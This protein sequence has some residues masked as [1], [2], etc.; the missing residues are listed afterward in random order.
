MK[1]LREKIEQEQ[2]RLR[3]VLGE[4]PWSTGAY[5]H[6][7]GEMDG[8]KKTLKWLDEEEQS[9]E[10]KANGM[11]DEASGNEDQKHPDYTTKYFESPWKPISDKQNNKPMG[12]PTGYTP[13]QLCPKCEAKKKRMSKEDFFDMVFDN[14]DPTDGLTVHLR[15]LWD[16]NDAKRIFSITGL[17]FYELLNSN[18]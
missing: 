18:K 14:Y 3:N 2:K 8:L 15:H 4:H 12:I 7:C 5:G 10:Q 16:D 13:C 11:N 6:I 1:T 17:S 9:F